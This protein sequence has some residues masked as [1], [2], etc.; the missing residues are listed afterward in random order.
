MTPDTFFQQG[1][2]AYDAGISTLSNPY[3][4]DHFPDQHSYWLQGWLDA[5]SDKRYAVKRNNRVIKFTVGVVVVLSA[6][7]ATLI[8]VA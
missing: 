8:Y 4:I 3:S 7:V 5:Q 1:R 6:L 2:Q